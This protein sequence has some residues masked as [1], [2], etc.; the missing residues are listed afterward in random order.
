MATWKAGLLGIAC[1]AAVVGGIIAGAGLA[2]SLIGAWA[3]LIPLLGLIAI[4]GWSIGV[5]RWGRK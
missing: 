4:G 1:L 2:I 5:D 3:L